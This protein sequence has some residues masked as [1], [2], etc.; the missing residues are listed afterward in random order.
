MSG[1]SLPLLFLVVPISYGT[2]VAGYPRQQVTEE[3]EMMLLNLLPV[4]LVT[5]AECSGVS[6]VKPKHM[7]S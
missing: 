3:Q 6:I 5:S 4:V 7:Q 2:L 1:P